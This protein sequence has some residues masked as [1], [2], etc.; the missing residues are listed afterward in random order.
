MALKTTYKD[1]IPNTPTRRY[2]LINNEDGTVSFED[3]T[4]YSQIGDDFAA[5]DVNEITKAINAIDA[6]GWVTKVRL[7][8][9][10]QNLLTETPAYIIVGYAANKAFA[11][12]IVA[13]SG[14]SNKGAK[15]IT[16]NGSTI[17]FQSDGIYQIRVWIHLNTGV[18]RSF[19]D[20]AFTNGGSLS[21]VTIRSSD[22]QN[23]LGTSGD[24]AYELNATVALKAGATMAM[25][26]YNS[27]ATTV[28]GTT[29]INQNMSG[30][31]IYKVGNYPI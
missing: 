31:T 21:P 9:E 4:V 16:Y 2:N 11:S 17:T 6:S 5:L 15:N 22:T 27:G 1:D 19:V 13:M 24:P 8:T 7:S 29:T 28:Y 20:L 14:M 30:V 26:I 25:T 10:V 23:L 3:A 12:G 18:G